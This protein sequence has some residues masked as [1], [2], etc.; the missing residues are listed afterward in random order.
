[1]KLGITGIGIISPL[2]TGKETNWKR[3]INSESAVKYNKILDIHSA[4]VNG[5]VMQ[6]SE[7][8]YEMAKSA[9]LEAV[10]DAGLNNSDFDRKRIGLC[11][12]ESK[13]NLFRNDFSLENSLINKLKETF[14]FYGESITLSAACA[15]GIL[16]IIK[17]CQFIKN[18]LCDAVICGCSET[19]IHP[20]Y[21]AGLKNMGVLTKHTPTPFDK[22]RDGFAV[23]EGACFV[24]IENIEKDLTRNVKAYYEIDGVSNGIYSDNP[25]SINSYKSMVSIIRKAANSQTPDYIHAHGTGT[26]LN[27]RNESLAIAK[28]FKGTDK[29]SIS[30]TKAATGHM[31]SI[32]G[33]AGVVF[34]ILA[35]ENNIVPPTLNFKNTDI[36]LGLDYTPNLAKEK[37]INSALTL[38]FGFGG[39]GCAL[40]LKKFTT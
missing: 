26:K 21:I 13:I 8:Q 12:G 34:S 17:G 29:I 7:R 37:I 10:S 32:S 28:T 15:T 33:L 9:I 2:G 6:E 31:L 39:Q 36:N 24:V 35:M 11:L 1:M 19:S 27:D 22:N 38:S 16:T 25:L 40:F 14:C 18:R 23:G 5:F 3:L 20:L 30:S 4:C